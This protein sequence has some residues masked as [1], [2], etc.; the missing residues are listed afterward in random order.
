[1][2]PRE[3]EQDA[4]DGAGVTAPAAWFRGAVDLLRAH[5]GG[6][7]DA[8]DG[9]VAGWVDGGAKLDFSAVALN[10]GAGDPE[11][12]SGTTLALGGEEGLTEPTLD[13]GRNAAAVVADGDANATDA[14]VGPA[15]G[16]ANAEAQTALVG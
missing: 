12:Q 13:I 10:D 4:A 8:E 9:T 15:A 1:M 11:T 16:G 14:G 6:Q 5:V 7:E 2:A 3:T